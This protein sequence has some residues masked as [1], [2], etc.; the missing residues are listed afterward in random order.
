MIGGRHALAALV[1]MTGGLVFSISPGTAA[2][3][4]QLLP[5]GDLLLPKGELLPPGKATPSTIA[6][7]RPSAP[8][9]PS[10]PQSEERDTARAHA[11]LFLES[12]Y[13][14]ANTCATCHPNQY[15]EWSVSQHSYSQLSPMMMSFQNV[16]NRRTA[17]TVGDFCLRCH[18][19]VGTELGEP[20][21][22]SNLDRDPA[23][24][25]GITCIVCHR[26]SKPYSK[27]AGRIALVEGDIFNPVYGP[28]GDAELKRVLSEPETYRVVTEPG[29]SGRAIHGDVEKFFTLTRPEFCATCH[30]VFNPI[31]FRLEEPISE[32]YHSPAA[33]KGVTCQDCHMGETQGAN[34]GYATGPAAVV[35]GVPTR[36]RKVTSHYFA[37]PDASIIHPGL[38]PHNVRA[39]E[40]KA[41]REWLE[42]DLKTGWGTPEFENKV[43]KDH[44]FPKAWRSA[45]DR[46]DAREIIKEQIKLLEWAQGKRVEVLRNGFSLSDIKL[47][48]GDKRGISFSVEVGN[49]AEGHNSP[50]GLDEER[51]IFLQV[52]VTD[53]TGKIIYMSGDRDPNGDLRD[54]SSLYVKAGTLPI[55]DDLFNLQSKF[56][57][58]ALHG[59]DR[60]QVLGTNTSPSVTPFMRPEARP[61]VLYGAPASVRKMRHTIPALQSRTATYSVPADRL[62]GQGPYRVNVKLIIQSVTVHLAY[63]VAPGGF[64]FGMTTKQVADALVQNAVVIWERDLT[65]DR[66]D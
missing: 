52:T 44:V 21:S 39:D 64:D 56:T 47:D 8:A 66:A 27:A 23:S 5:Q 46:Y 18:A 34:K 20:L 4:G 62:T 11:R 25:E 42:F 26:V 41:M 53:G 48:P 40:F 14:S 6:P 61:S 12:R 10:E 59:G 57:G 51:P 3:P 54:I 49:P 1:M 43:P 35:G 2:E 58:R 29:K 55:D 37:G 65:I 16:T 13:P 38:F 36:P 7:V 19:P 17:T 24:R 50:T 9:A 15:R 31:G 28:T 32:Y 22:L 30:E 60:V 33:A 45:D 63:A